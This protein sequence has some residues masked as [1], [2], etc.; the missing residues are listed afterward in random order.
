MLVTSN[1]L[2]LK[3]MEKSPGVPGAFPFPDQGGNNLLFF[4]TLADGSLD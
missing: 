4:K 2:S 3:Q 1:L